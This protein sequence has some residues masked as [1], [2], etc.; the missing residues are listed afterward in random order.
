MFFIIPLTSPLSWLDDEE[1]DLSLLYMDS[2][3]YPGVIREDGI[4]QRLSLERRPVEESFK[5]GGGYVPV[6]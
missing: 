2:E 4:V 1:N 5:E 6:N 3:M